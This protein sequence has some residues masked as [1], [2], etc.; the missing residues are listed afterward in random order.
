MIRI[1]KRNDDR[2]ALHSQALVVEHKFRIVDGLSLLDSGRLTLIE[3]SLHGGDTLVD[4]R[5]ELI[6]AALLLIVTGLSIGD[7][8]F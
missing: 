8:L 1:G 7:A 6:D 5:G 3:F 2:P 4:L